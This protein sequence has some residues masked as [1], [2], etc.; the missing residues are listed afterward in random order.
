MIFQ[1]GADVMETVIDPMLLIFYII[2]SLMFVASSYK[3]G[4]IRVFGI[5]VVLMMGAII[6][7]IIGIEIIEAIFVL[8]ASLFAMIGSIILRMKTRKLVL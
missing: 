8:S 7:C 5:V 3:K 2:A 1:E 6:W 4:D